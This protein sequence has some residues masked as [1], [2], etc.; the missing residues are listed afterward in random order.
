[1]FGTDPT[2][3]LANIATVIALVAPL[4]T[5]LHRRI[6]RLERESHDRTHQGGHRSVRR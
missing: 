1:M 2:T 4:F 3:A 5:Y 6:R